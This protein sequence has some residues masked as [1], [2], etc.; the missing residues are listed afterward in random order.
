VAADVPRAD[1]AAVLD[2]LLERTTGVRRILYVN[3][4]DTD[5]AQALNAIL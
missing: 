5:L 3:A 2:E 1:V 4:G